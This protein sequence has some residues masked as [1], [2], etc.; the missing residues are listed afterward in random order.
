MVDHWILL[1]RLE[2]SYNVSGK[3]LRWF[4]SYLTG[5][6]QHVRCRSSRSF[7]TIVLCG[8]PQGSVLGPIQFLLYMADLIRL[9]E[10]HSLHP[11]TYVDD[12]KIYG[13]C[14][15]SETS[16]LQ[17][18]LTACISD[19]AAWMRANRLQLN[20]AKTE[21]L[22]C[23]SNRRKYQ[24]PQEPLL[25]EAVTVTQASAVRDLGYYL[26]SDVS[27]WTHVM[28]TVYS[29]FAVLRQLRTVRRSVSRSVLRSMTVAL[30][31]KRL[32][33]GNAGLAGASGCLLRRLQFILN[34]AARKIYSTRSRQHVAPL[35]RS[36]HWLN[37]P[38]RIEYKLSV[39]VY[40]C[41]H[42]TAPT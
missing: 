24:I 42:G 31:N 9:I 4:P 25:V 40:C 35:L 27:M 11:H 10:Q 5:R 7:S 23:A 30:V 19:V 37:V 12:T 26:D 2:L 32:D 28:R 20:T 1:R 18:R 33:Y 8:V 3:A 13:S 16:E 22:W 21:L 15:P 38:E 34:A 6:T 36:L 29:C 39:L 41:L 17:E 14:A